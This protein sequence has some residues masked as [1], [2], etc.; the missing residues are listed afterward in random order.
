MNN[1]KPFDVNKIT[2]IY[3][4]FMVK[5]KGSLKAQCKSKVRS[6]FRKKSLVCY[7]FS[8]LMVTRIY[9]CKQMNEQMAKE[10]KIGLSKENITLRATF[11]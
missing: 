6:K 10:A 3:S 4:V 7:N 9:N 11:S 8:T 2:V 1:L 5:I